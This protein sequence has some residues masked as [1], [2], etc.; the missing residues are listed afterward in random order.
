VRDV[1]QVEPEIRVGFAPA[2]PRNQGHLTGTLIYLKHP[3]V[4]SGFLSSPSCLHF[5]RHH[6]GAGKYA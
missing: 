5:D 6:Q 4:Q 1:A 2:G 3:Y